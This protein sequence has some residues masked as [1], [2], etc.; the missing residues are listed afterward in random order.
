MD[1]SIK[2]TNKK[3]TYNFKV[4]DL[5]ITAMFAAVICVLSPFAIPTQPIPFTLSL[6]TIFLTGAVLAPRYA[7]LATLT[8][9]L[10]GLCGI[11][12]FSNFGSGPEK[13]VG[14]TGGYL[15]AYPLMAFLTA[16][17]Y[18]YIKVNKALALAIGMLVSLFLCYLLGTLWFTIVTD[19]SFYSA[20]FLCVIPYIPFDLLK[21]AL[22]ISVG[23]MLR[24]TVL[25][26][27]I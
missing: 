12:V 4:I 25:K 26:H 17:F 20:L 24:K 3:S 11:P 1:N 23:L 15:M 2:T 14:P 13:F 7:F 8:Y 27:I 21:I 9:L 18:K 5:V 16:I 10:I 22:A 19:N 6:F